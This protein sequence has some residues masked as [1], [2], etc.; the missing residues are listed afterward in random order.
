MAFTEEQR[1]SVFDIIHESIEDNDI[2][3]TDTILSAFCD[4]FNEGDSDFD[5]EE[6]FVNYK[7]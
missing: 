2:I 1:K 4:L 5:Y 7:P 3:F 6:E